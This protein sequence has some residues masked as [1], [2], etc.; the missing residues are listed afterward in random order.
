LEAEKQG[1]E[2]LAP[3][4]YLSEF[5][6][7]HNSEYAAWPGREKGLKVFLFVDRFCGLKGVPF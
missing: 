6:E 5:F 1:Q 3:A 4:F 2:K 7:K